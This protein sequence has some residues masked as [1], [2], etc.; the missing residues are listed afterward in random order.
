MIRRLKKDVLTMLPD[1]TRIRVR[2]DPD[3]IDKQ[4]MKQLKELE[5]GPSDGEDHA[6]ETGNAGPDIQ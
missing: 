3:K 4:A 1:K 6:I 2:A 5:K